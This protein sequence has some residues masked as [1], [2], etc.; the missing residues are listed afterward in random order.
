[1]ENTVAFLN[2]HGEKL[3]GT[4]HL[5][6][7]SADR[8]VIWGHCFTCS[9][10][11]TVLRD[12]SKKLEE[13]GIASLRFDFSG[14]GQSEG[15]FSHTSY[16]RHIAEM[17]QAVNFLSEKGFSCFAAGGHSMGAAIAVLAAERMAAESLNIKAVCALAGRLG[18]GKLSQ[19]FTRDQMEELRQ[20]GR[21]SFVSRGRKLELRE[22]FFTDM[23]KYD[24]AETVANLKIPLM[25]IHGDKD[26]VIS[27]ENALDAKKHNPCAELEIVRDA[28]HMFLNPGHRAEIAERAAAWFLKIFSAR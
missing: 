1:M 14:N 3:A 25:V 21:V 12:I 27:V 19:I 28:D 17:K 26:E 7:K 20:T 5:P 4:L 11:T 2:E 16:S 23:Q 8:A 24:L 15:D 22:D 13:K 9:R 10:H 18:T 6:E